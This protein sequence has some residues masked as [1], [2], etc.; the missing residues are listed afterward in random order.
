[1]SRSFLGEFEATLDTKGRFLIPAGFK[2][3]LKEGENTFVLNRGLEK[4]IT[5]YPMDV[6]EPLSKQINSLNQFDP[7][8]RRFTRQFLGGA[9][10]VEM[11]GAGRMLLPQTLKEH[12]DL[13]KDIIMVAVGD[14]VEIW[15]ATKYKKFFEDFSPHEFSAL[16]A[17]VMTGNS[18]TKL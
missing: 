7:N 11:D 10:E 3:Q 8:V 16:A 1:M 9:T 14:K 4:C 13:Q 18:E 17:Q 12:A 5:L 15:D 6:W 2:K